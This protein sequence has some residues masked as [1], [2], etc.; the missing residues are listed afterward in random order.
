LV[1]EKY[2]ASVRSITF[3]KPGNTVTVGGATSYPFY[4][5]EGSMPNKPKVAMEV[6]DM[7]PDEWPE[8]C[9]A[10][11]KDVINNPPAW[12]KKNAKINLVRILLFYN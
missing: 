12:A 4:L 11:F 5:F 7:E 3:G 9:I 1:K 10:P 2:N 8:A 6:W